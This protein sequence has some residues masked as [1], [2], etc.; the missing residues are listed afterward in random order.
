MAANPGMRNPPGMVLFFLVLTIAS[1]AAVAWG[2][3]TMT[4]ANEAS[5]QGAAVAVGLAVGVI[6]AGMLYIAIRGWRLALALGR[7]EGVLARWTVSPDD[8]KTFVAND[9]ARNA[10][11]PEYQNDWTPPEES[12]PGGLEVV[13]GKDIVRVGDRHFGLVNTGMFVFEGVQILPENPLAIEFGTRATSLSKGASSVHVNV[14]TGL[15]RIPIGRLA[16]A[17]AARVLDHY[18]RVDSHEIVVNPGFYKGRMRFGLIAAPVCFVAAALGYLMQEAGIA[19]IEVNLV[20][21]IGGI[22]AGLGAL[23]LALIAAWLSHLQY[24]RRV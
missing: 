12:P 21:M 3:L 9:A 20:L 23:V 18:K 10:L 15:L 14:V 5:A 2:A 11:G 7:G 8:Y 4:D 24:A 22:I 13:F 17:D 19:T 6:S 16:R 1:A